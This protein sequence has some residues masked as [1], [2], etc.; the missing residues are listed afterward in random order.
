M[1]L[2]TNRPRLDDRDDYLVGRPRAWF[3]FA[4]IFLLMLFDYIDRQVI[5]SL[6]PRL[7]E[8]WSLSDKQL[9]GLVW[10]AGQAYR[11][12]E[13]PKTTDYRIFVN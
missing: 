10:D 3:A 8:A 4:M 2:N 9:G 5:G 7:K 13:S 11:G 12:L 1:N 6:F